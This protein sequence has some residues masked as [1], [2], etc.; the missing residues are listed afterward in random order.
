MRGHR[1][2][3]RSSIMPTSSTA[4][5][6]S[7]VSAASRS[8]SGRPTTTS[9]PSS[10]PGRLPVPPRTITIRISTESWNVKLVGSMAPMRVAKKAPA[11]PPHMPPI[12]YAKSFRRSEGTPNDSAANSSSRIAAQP[13][14]IEVLGEDH[15]DRQQEEADDEEV[16]LRVELVPEKV[17]P[18]DGKHA[19][20]AAGDLPVVE[21]DESH[22]AESQGHDGEVV[23][24]QAQRGI[25]Q[26]RAGRA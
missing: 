6:S 14:M 20:G 11:R 12:T 19:G 25:A 17:G 5:T 9:A 8:T 26:D 3:G 23:A 15:R 10:T 16:A 1:P 22:L 7:R 13:R 2:C 4:K 18:R 24:A 21:R